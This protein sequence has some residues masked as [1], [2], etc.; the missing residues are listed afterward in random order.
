VIKNAFVHVMLYV[1]VAVL[2]IHACGGEHD[3]TKAPAAS[4]S[5]QQGE[6]LAHR[7]VN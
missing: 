2:L 7:M 3:S 5:A 6:S 4:S 1:G